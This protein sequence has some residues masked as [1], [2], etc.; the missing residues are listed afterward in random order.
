MADEIAELQLFVEIVRAGGLLFI[1]AA[2]SQPVLL[3]HSANVTHM[4]TA[5]LD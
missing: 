1:A 3:P 4:Q 2:E 5:F